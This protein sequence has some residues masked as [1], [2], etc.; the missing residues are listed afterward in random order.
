MRVVVTDG[1]GVDGATLGPLGPAFGLTGASGGGLTGATFGPLGPV[2]G[3]T[4]ARGWGLTGATSGLGGG[5]SGLGGGASGLGGGASALSGATSVLGSRAS[6]LFGAVSGSTGASAGGSPS[7]GSF[8]GCAARV[9]VVS[10]QA[11]RPSGNDVASTTASVI[12]FLFPC[13]A[14]PLSGPISPP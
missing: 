7:V 5:A 10:P 9:R 11:A 6:G 12:S 8:A 2:F 1:P 13:M 14:G 4:G 3:R